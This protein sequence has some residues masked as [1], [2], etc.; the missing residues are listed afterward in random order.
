[1]T[2]ARAVAAKLVNEDPITHEFI[3]GTAAQQEAHE[4]GPDVDHNGL[5]GQASLAPGETRT[6][7]FTFGKSGSLIFACHRPGHYAYGMRGTITIA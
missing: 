3:I 1:M 7:S 4:I 5:P 2:L 6:I